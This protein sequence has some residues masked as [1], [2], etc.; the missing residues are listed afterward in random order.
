MKRSLLSMLMALVAIMTPIGAWAQQLSKPL[1][2]C[3]TGI[4]T[5]Y[6]PYDVLLPE[7]ARAYI[8]TD[9]ITHDDGTVQLVEEELT[10]GIPALTA[11]VIRG[12]G[13]EEQITLE[14]TEGLEPVV[15]EDNNLLKGTLVPISLDASNESPNFM[16]F[17]NELY[18][19]YDEWP[20]LADWTT[21]AHADGTTSFTLSANQAFLELPVDAET[22]TLDKIQELKALP[23]LQHTHG[24][25]EICGQVTS[26]EAIQAAWGSSADDLTS[27]GTLADAVTAAAQVGSSVGYIKLQEDV[28]S[29]EGYN[30]NGGTFTLDLNGYTLTSESHTLYIQNAGTSV[31]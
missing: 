4:T 24:G 14:F 27:S 1:K 25:C 30:I 8:V 26:V 6:L 16:L 19:L 10:G 9:I 20:A 3:K 21:Y 29:T 13:N 15:E 7:G 28:A 31:T 5:L 11:V 23:H 22:W 12:D 18:E 2:M 17:S